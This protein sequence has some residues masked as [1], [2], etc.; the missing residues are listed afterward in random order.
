[1]EINVISL[2][3]TSIISLLIHFITI[4]PASYINGNDAIFSS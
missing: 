4:L 2:S 3:L 1:M